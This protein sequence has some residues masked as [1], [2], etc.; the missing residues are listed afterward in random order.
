MLL[1]YPYSTFVKN[2]GIGLHM[3]S[4]SRVESRGEDGRDEVDPDN[5]GSNDEA[6]N[7]SIILTG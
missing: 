2:P 6:L 7:E 3:G 4:G 5:I 1:F